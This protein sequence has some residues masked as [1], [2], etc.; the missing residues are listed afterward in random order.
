MRLYW[1]MVVLLGLVAAASGQTIIR[2]DVNLV[3]LMFVARDSQGKLIDDLTQDEIE[4]FEDSLPQKIK[5]FAKSTDL[6]L[7]LALIVD[8]SGSQ[9]HFG[10]EHRKDLE[11]F[12]QEVLRPQDRA[13]LVCFGNHLRLVSDYTNS[14]SQLL[15]SYSEF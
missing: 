3:N 6:P 8:A 9:D 11:L 7:T 10:K 13:F 1:I 12:L 15:E 4:V 5:F 2:D 14:A